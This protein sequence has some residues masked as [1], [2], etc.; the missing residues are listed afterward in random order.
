MSN[1]PTVLEIDVSA[2]QHNL[3]YFKSRISEHTKLLIVIKAFAY[4]SDSIAVAKILEKEKVDYLAVVYTDEG[5]AL[6]KAGITLPI[7]VLHPQIENFEHIINYDLEPN[8][9][10]FRTL[11]AFVELS[12]QK[13]LND[14]PVHIKLNTG[15]NR[16]GFNENDLPKIVEII[17]NENSIKII[18]FY[19]HLAASEDLTEKEFTNNQI[20]LFE[21]MTAVLSNSLAYTSLKHLANTS[22]ILNYPEA[23]FDMVRL[24]IGFYGFGNNPKE[25]VHLKNVCNLKT[26]ISQIQVLKN[27]DTVGYNRK[28]VVEK[29]NKIAILPIGY[30]DGLNRNLG[31]SKG[32]VYIQAQKAPII[33]NICMDIIMVD[34]TD[35]SC[36]EGDEVVLFNHQNH[37]LDFATILNT[38]PY[39]ILTSISQRV[40]RKLIF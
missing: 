27:G 10:S 29:P 38:I 4:G 31:N 8:L 9:Y 21:K 14:F 6:R 15:M 2:M 17:K 1:N 24:G 5:I 3:N 23:Q 40:E 32:C 12:K 18:S 37:V 22:A 7:L 34:V 25:T 36:E 13:K 20:I 19:S 28:F 30:A 35:I 26:K 33:G 16:L 11:Q 39:E